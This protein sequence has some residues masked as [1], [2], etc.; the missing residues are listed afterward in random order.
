[1][2]GWND[3]SFWDSDSDGAK[4]N[5][6]GLIA[7]FFRALSSRNSSLIA[8]FEKPHL[9]SRKQLPRR[10]LFFTPLLSEAL[11]T[12]EARDPALS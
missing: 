3:Q 9:P 1:L 2:P 12:A 11:I 10:S 7:S 6:I 4:N 5:E 8:G